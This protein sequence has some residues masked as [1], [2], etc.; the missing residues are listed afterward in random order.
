[1][2]FPTLEFTIFCLLTLSLWIFASKEKIRLYLLIVFNIIFYSY[3]NVTLTLYLVAWSCIVWIAGKHLNM[4]FLA[5][6]TGILQLVFWKMV[7]ANY[8]EFQSFVTPLGI[9]FFTFQGLTY[10]FARMKF[11]PHRQDEHLDDAWTFSYVF[12]FTGFFPTV[13]SGPI[14]RAKYWQTQ[15]ENP[16][17]F[18]QKTINDA[19]TLIALGAFYKLC[20]SSIFHDYVS[21]A[22]SSP[23]DETGVNLIIGLYAYT[24]E[25]YHDFA[26]YSLMAIGIAL[27]YGFKIPDNFKQP[28]LST[29]IRTF[30]QKWHISFST[31][32][33]DYF[34]I[35][36]GGSKV[37]KTRHLTNTMIIMIVCGAWHGLSGNY[38]VWGL[39]HG[40]AVCFY[41]L[42]K[43]YVKLP[44]PV[45]WFITFNYVACAW[46]FF[47]SPD[48]QTGID[49]FM[50]M[51]SVQSWTTDFSIK[52]YSLIALF[53]ICLLLQKIEPFILNNDRQYTTFF[54]NK[55]TMPLIWVVIFILILIVSPS[56]MPPFIYFSY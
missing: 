42:I 9:S 12:A 31:W 43:D 3:L 56:G 40:L 25:I 38:L 41:H 32:L 13:L 36:L 49:Y 33:R 35:A 23:K 46:I 53:I 1:M 5:I 15:F 47:R 44:T 24:F 18:S 22:F 8:I 17:V 11:P 29:N 54:F 39:L 21:V 20:L 27:L 28:Y 6:S 26:G 7:D 2:L 16:V 50:T 19:L 55:F 14:L 10:I 51:F 4:K 52:H 34:Y 48:I 30:W 37:S 45:S